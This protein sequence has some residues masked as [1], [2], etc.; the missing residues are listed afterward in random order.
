MPTHDFTLE[1]DIDVAPSVLHGFLCDLNN[2][3]PLHP[4]IESIKELTPSIELPRAR[5]YRVADRIPLGP[6]SLPTVYVAALDAVS[7]NEVHGY[8]WQFP[9]IRLHTV[10]SLTAT[11]LG[12]HL[13]ESVS[14]KAPALLHRFVVNQARRAHTETLMK[15]KALLELTSGSSV[16][17]NGGRTRD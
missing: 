3:I 11:S 13:V 1:Q 16:G 17:L 15:M 10:Y 5:R 8:A 6:F 12:T 4:F 14:V 9:S 2:Y 7:R